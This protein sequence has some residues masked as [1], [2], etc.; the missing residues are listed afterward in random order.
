VFNG[1]IHILLVKTNSVI[2]IC[3]KK[4]GRKGVECVLTVRDNE[5]DMEGIEDAS[6]EVA[7]GWEGSGK[8]YGTEQNTW[9]T[10]P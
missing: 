10:G 1:H 6:L 8:S 3:H 5:L 4:H 2:Y 9:G 7:E